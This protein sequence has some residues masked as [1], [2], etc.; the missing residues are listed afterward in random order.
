M[1]IMM[2]ENSLNRRIKELKKENPQ[3]DFKAVFPHNKALTNC[4]V[5]FFKPEP[6][7]NSTSDNYLIV[8]NSVV[9][10]DNHK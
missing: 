7:T 10:A 2:R 6:Q 1:L 4:E 3:P 5:T 8:N 9:I